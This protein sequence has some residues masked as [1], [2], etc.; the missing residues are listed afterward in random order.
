L[1]GTVRGARVV[2]VLAAFLAGAVLL[3]TQ[4]TV[5]A[6]GVAVVL[7]VLTGLAL[8]S[9]SAAA[10]DA[11]LM[12]DLLYLAVAV[13][14]LG[15][16]PL[17][18][19]VAVVV[20]WGLAYRSP[21][22]TFWRSWLHRGHNTPETPWLLLATVAVTALAL[23]AWQQV[24]HGQLPD[25]YRDAAQGQPVWLV[26]VAGAGF[27]L[28][29]AA[30]EEAIFRGVL[31]TSLQPLIGPT[32]AV[33]VQAATFGLLHVVG[34]PTGLVGAD[35]RLMGGTARRDASPHTRD[36]GALSGPHCRRPDDR[37]YRPARPHLSRTEPHAP[38]LSSPIR[39]DTTV[40]T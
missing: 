13:G 39:A 11:V 30:V 5:T 25:A 2:A 27:A 14:V 33:L 40:P 10:L 18:A 24:F 9:G 28:V 35:G 8:R 19:A 16:W 26:L 6:V 23:L 34:I 29:N 22:A 17:P 1:A 20:A 38:A 31:Q 36:S 32:A 7:V 21:R 37:H 15:L 4:G 12:T 3:L